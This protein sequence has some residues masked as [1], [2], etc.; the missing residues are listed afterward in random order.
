[1]LFSLDVMLNVF[2]KRGISR[3]L[4]I[5]IKKDLKKIKHIYQKERGIWKRLRLTNAKIFNC[6]II[7]EGLGYNNKKTELEN[8]KQFVIDCEV[9]GADFLEQYF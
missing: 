7:Q 8:W 9:G 2:G 4:I 3:E 5:D 1:M 6:Y